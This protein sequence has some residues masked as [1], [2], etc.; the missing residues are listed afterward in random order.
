MVD[1]YSY[2]LRFTSYTSDD[3]FFEGSN[4]GRSWDGGGGYSNNKRNYLSGY[5]RSE[6]VTFYRPDK[7]CEDKDIGWCL[8]NGFQ[9]ISKGFW[10]GK[11]YYEEH[12]EELKEK[13]EKEKAAAEK[14]RKAAEKLA[15]AEER[16]KVRRREMLDRLYNNAQERL[17]LDCQKKG[18][19]DCPIVGCQKTFETEAEQKDH[20]LRQGGK[21]HNK[22]RAAH[23]IGNKEQEHVQRQDGTAHD[24]CRT[25][26]EMGTTLEE[27]RFRTTPRHIRRKD[28]NARPRY[29]TAEEIIAL[30]QG[31]KDKCKPPPSK[32]SRRS[33]KVGH[34][35][36]KASCT[37]TNGIETSEERRNT[38][39]GT[40]ENLG[41][42]EGKD[43]SMGLGMLQ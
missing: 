26:N 13:E 17:L 24:R 9:E 19:F 34:D 1:C 25:A 5:R 31:I 12:P 2:L 21:G 4:G 16:E 23:G 42:I 40:G 3:D 11:W 35:K 38:T 32:V 27:K 20:I 14:K 41:T 30:L 39:I 10:S 18:D 28:E 37:T 7:T 36:A 22:Y 33:T 8:D 43:P 6:K 29:R 15:E